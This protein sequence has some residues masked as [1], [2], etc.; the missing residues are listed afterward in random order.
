[1]AARHLCASVS[2]ERYAGELFE[3]VHVGHDEIN[4]ADWVGIHIAEQPGSM[5]ISTCPPIRTARWRGHLRTPMPQYQRQ[6]R[7][8][9]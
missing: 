1:M 4:Q 8:Y 2:I 9:K 5:R 3:E 7:S 6:K